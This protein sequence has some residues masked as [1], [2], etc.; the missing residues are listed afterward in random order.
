MTFEKFKVQVSFM[1]STTLR[2]P[3]ENHDRIEKAIIGA[4]DGEP[5]LAWNDLVVIVQRSE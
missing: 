2:E 5:G 3:P 1:G 4:L